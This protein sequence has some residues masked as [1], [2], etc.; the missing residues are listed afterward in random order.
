MYPVNLNI[1]GRL[2]LVVGGGKVA[3]RKVVSLLNSDAQV[4]L[5][6]PT[7][8]DELQDLVDTHNIELRKRAYKSEDVND[9][10]CVFATTNDFVT[11]NLV[12]R[13]AKA[14][15]ALFNSASDSLACDFQVPA[16]IQ[17][18]DFL[19]TVSTGGSSPAFSRVVRQKLEKEFGEEYGY[20]SL[21]M[22]IIRKEILLLGKSSNSNRDVFRALVAAKPL[23][24][25]KNAQW[26]DLEQCLKD[27]LPPELDAKNII[28]KFL[29]E[30]EAT[31]VL[32]KF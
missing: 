19:L 27:H 12:M 28:K 8:E 25:I 16:Q 13:D 20:M 10:F 6:S 29:E 30:V 24:I 2:C 4:R 26:D 32:T 14:C 23:D 31:V 15:G 22:A 17:R 3:L 9:T 7:L 11:Q 18:G 21:L 1:S 5:V